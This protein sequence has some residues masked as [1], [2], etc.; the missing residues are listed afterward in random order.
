[1]RLA[2][3]SSLLPA[4]TRGGA[5]VYVERS[6][7]TLAEWHDVFVLTGSAS[8]VEGIPT[9]RLPSLPILDRSKPAAVRV[10]WHAL[11]QWLPSVHRRLSRELARIRPDIVLTHEPQGLSAAVFTAVAWRRLA[12]V[13]TAHD[14]N[15][16]CARVSMTR[17]GEFCGGRCL[18]CRPQRII[19]TRAVKLDISRLIGVSRYICERHIEA[20]VI[21]AERAIAL[22]LGA[23]AKAG[24]LRR[25]EGRSVTLGFI[26]TLGGHKGVRTLLRAMSSSDEP[27][28]LLIAGAGP[29][30]AEVEA[31]ARDDAR[32]EY[33]GHVTAEAKDDFFDRCDLMVIPS[34]W[35]E[36]ATFVAIEAAVRGIPAVVS[37][38]G[39]LPETP[40]ARTFRS[41]DAQELVDAIHWYLADPARIEQASRRLLAA[42][43]EFEWST[44]VERVRAVLDEV[45]SE[46]L[47]LPHGAR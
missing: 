3:V 45:A 13:H 4:D 21:P 37:A 47:S 12:H 23:D 26:G 34:E 19:R 8:T 17:G 27:W 24:R 25:V 16:L 18:G 11:D 35:E 20:G 7:Q 5:E 6:A 41:G 44:H 36:P 31:A 39:G 42:R 43:G 15:L 2:L 28:R 40:E 9:I 46:R 29:L 14:L 10:L 38:R 33:L 32:I 30:E 1:V 22:R